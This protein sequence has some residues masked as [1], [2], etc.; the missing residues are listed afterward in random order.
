MAAPTGTDAHGT[1]S[2]ALAFT[3]RKQP[4]RKSNGSGPNTPEPRSPTKHRAK[5][6]WH[7]RAISRNGLFRV[8]L[9]NPRCGHPKLQD[10][11]RKS[12]RMAGG[13]PDSTPAG[14][15]RSAHESAHTQQAREG[16]GWHSGASVQAADLPAASAAENEKTPA[17]AAV[18]GTSRG[19]QKQRLRSESNRRWR[20]CN[21]LP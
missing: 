12:S 2:P 21:P 18:V 9:A 6:S 19:F 7:W 16:S 20:I 4:P 5:R 8:V 11:L 15:G 1:T 3:F 17:K 14:S 13:K 10:F